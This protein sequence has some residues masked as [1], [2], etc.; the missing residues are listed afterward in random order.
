[1][2]HVQ[3]SVSFPQTSNRWGVKNFIACFAREI[4]PH[5][6][7]RGATPARNAR[8]SQTDLGPRSPLVGPGAVSG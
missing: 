8:L 7:N 4:V 3:C 1:M 5:V 6:Q 2:K